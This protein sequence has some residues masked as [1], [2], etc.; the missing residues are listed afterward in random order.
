MTTKSPHRLHRVARVMGREQ[1]QAG[2]RLAE[3]R[4]ALTES[5]RQ[6]EV[7]RGYVESYSGKAGASAEE[8]MR[9]SSTQELQNYSNFLTQ[10]NQAVRQQETHVVGAQRAFDSQIQTW[11]QARARTRSIEKVAD[12]HADADQRHQ[13]RREQRELDDLVLRRHFEPAI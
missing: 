3:L 9:I 5:E 12:R 6:L 7:L 2:R 11:K 13:E 8:R 1:E 10:L 4:D